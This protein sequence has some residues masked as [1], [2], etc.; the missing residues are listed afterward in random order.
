MCMQS[1]AGKQRRLR[2]WLAELGRASF[3]AASLSLATAVADAQ[4]DPFG[5]APAKPN[6]AASPAAKPNGAPAGAE[7]TAAETDPAVLSVRESKPTTPDQLARAIRIMLDLGRPDE[8]AR[9]LKRLAAA[10]VDDA[11]WATL[12]SRYGAELFLRIIKHEQ[13]QPEG[14][15]VGRMALAA[16]E[17]QARNPARLQTLV[18]KLSDPNQATRRDAEAGLRDAGV[19]AVAPL[20]AVLSDDALTDEHRAVQQ[21]LVALGAQAVEPLLGALENNNPK[22]A[23]R[24]YPV[25]GALKTRRA[26]GYLV[27]PAIGDGVDPE[28][29]DAARDALRTI[30]GDVPEYVEATQFLYKRA[31]GYLTGEPPVHIGSDDRGELWHWDAAAKRSVRSSYLSHDL[32]VIE[33]TRLARELNRLAP[34]QDEYRLLYLTS[35]LEA[36][37][38]L[39]GV[40]QPLPR[41]EGTA[42]AHAATQRVE[43]IEQL[44]AYAMKHQRYLAAAA[45]I[46]VLGEIGDEELLTATD[47]SPRRLAAA[48]T[49]PDRRVRFSAVAAVIKIDPQQSY[50]GAS[51][52]AESLGYL[53]G[54][55]G[56]RRALV[57]HPR[58]KEAQSLV[59]LLAE[60]GYAADAVNSGRAAYIQ[61]TRQPDYEFALLSDSVQ[62]PAVNELVQ[63]LRQETRTARLPVG[64]FAAGES[65]DRAQRLA[66]NEPLTE[67]FPRPVDPE[68]LAVLVDRLK[69]GIGRDAVTRDERLLHAAL[70]LEWIEQLTA[71]DQTYS[72]YELSRQE[73]AIETALQT[74]ELASR[75]AAVLGHFGT[76]RAQ[77]ALVDLASHV[78]RAAPDR[79]AAVSAFR[80][81]VKRRGLMLT[82]DE[83]MRQYERYNQSATADRETQRILG[84]ILDILELRV[85]DPSAPAR[86]QPAAPKPAA[87]PAPATPSPP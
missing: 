73:P 3:I 32:G 29:R 51:Y 6:A 40:D 59:G 35:E 22:L 64:V 70:A 27:R 75:A 46:E 44:L 81:A 5:D 16:V 53:A 4:D 42:F 83:V 23:A 39:H 25:L 30:V 14:A 78:N 2:R 77:I 15:Q 20:V 87:Q 18:A 79:W 41:G 72:F 50:P 62:S 31:M 57:V 19:D 74:P 7:P 54:S 17:R 66:E 49:H 63:M 68:T 34:D 8:A 45:A 76:S 38:I 13:L 21:M 47:G 60:L 67:A 84:S 58:T 55:V 11:A 86:T 1:C 9:Y 85:A 10:N 56:S 43:V 69:A 36:A 48:L 80:E 33:A 37:K 28:R 26:I 12:H 24:I 52:L 61:A 71:D 65:L 82:R